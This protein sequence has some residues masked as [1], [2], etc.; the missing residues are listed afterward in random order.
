MIGRLVRAAGREEPVGRRVLVRARGATARGWLAQSDAGERQTAHSPAA[1]GS[2]DEMEVGAG[3]ED[4]EDELDEDAARG[5]FTAFQKPAR[6]DY[7]TTRGNKTMT[8]PPQ[9]FYN[10]TNCI[11]SFPKGNFPLEL[12]SCCM[13][14]RTYALP[15]EDDRHFEASTKLLSANPAIPP[16]LI[17][18]QG[19]PQLNISKEGSCGQSLPRN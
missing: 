12:K 1:D 7:E 19:S 11:R 6:R 10:T 16:S 5:H 9:P 18:L 2:D 14:C 8:F 15:K 13:I 3:V 17:C 4:G